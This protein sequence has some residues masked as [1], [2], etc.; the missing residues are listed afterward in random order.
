MLAA[1]GESQSA[2]GLKTDCRRSTLNSLI[3]GLDNGEYLNNQTFRRNINSIRTERD[4]ERWFQ[5][6]ILE[7]WGGDSVLQ[8]VGQD[9]DHLISTLG[10]MQVS[11]F[12][13]R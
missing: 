11:I 5:E 9:I 13:A 12:Y 1:A 6:F 4:L 2:S 7:E 8:I 3:F 10:S